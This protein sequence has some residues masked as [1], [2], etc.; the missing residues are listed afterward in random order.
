MGGARGMAIRTRGVAMMRMRGVVM[1]GQGVWSWGKRCGHDEDER[2]GHDGGKG[3]GHDG[4]L[5]VN[6][7]CDVG[8]HLYGYNDSN[9]LLA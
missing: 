6:K 1:M 4:D 3:C 5:D 9:L 7:R 2:G 8:A